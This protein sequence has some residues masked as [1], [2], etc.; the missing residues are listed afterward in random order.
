[1]STSDNQ[2][3]LTIHVP[4][5]MRKRSGRKRILSPDG[6]IPNLAPPKA[7]TAVVKAIARAFRWRDIL[8]SGV[9]ATIDELAK[10]EG[11]NPSYLSRTLRLTLLAP[12]IVEVLVN[13]TCDCQ[14]LLEMKKEIPTRW[15]EQRVR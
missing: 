12:K 10:A 8:E 9:Y 4:F 1:M 11:V 13:G 5:V 7:N 6:T 2:Q 15:D 3:T 14:S